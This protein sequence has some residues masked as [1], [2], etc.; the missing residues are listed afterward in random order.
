MSK[1]TFKKHQARKAHAK[2]LLDEGKTAEAIRAYQELLTQNPPHADQLYYQLGKA[3][4]TDEQWQ[5]AAEA[6]QQA[7]N[8]NP[9]MVGTERV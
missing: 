5:A 6:Y 9:K 4:F 3:L 7:L 2:N 1:R 8:K